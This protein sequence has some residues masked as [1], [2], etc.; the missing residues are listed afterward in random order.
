MD[1][2]NGFSTKDNWPA[3]AKNLPLVNVSKLDLP[4]LTRQKIRD[5]IPS[6]LRSENYEMAKLAISELNDAQ[7]IKAWLDG[8]TGLERKIASLCAQINDHTAEENLYRHKIRLLFALADTLRSVPNTQAII[9]IGKRKGGSLPNPDSQ[10]SKLAQLG[11][12][13]HD[14]AF[15]A[16]VAHVPTALREELISSSP[17]PSK[18]KIYNIGRAIKDKD[19]QRHPGGPPRKHVSAGFSRFMGNHR[20]PGMTHFIALARTADVN[21]FNEEEVS[22]TIVRIAALTDHLEGLRSTLESMRRDFAA[23]NA[24]K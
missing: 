20:A 18:N 24:R 2:D 11:M 6:A 23:S 16:A 21:D 4:A 3:V 17:P 15:F 9:P 14:G 10:R 7:T 8:I 19:A 1:N 22:V 12:T 5:L 13:K